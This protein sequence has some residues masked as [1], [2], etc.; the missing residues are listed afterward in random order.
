[1]SANAPAWHL[2]QYNIARLL[3][4]LD[5]PLLADFVA[6]LERVN[7]LGDASPGFVWRLQTDD[8]TSTSVRVRGD[9]RIIVNFTVWESI[10]AL[11]EFTY[12]SGHVEMYRRRREWFEHIAEAYLVLWWVPAGHIPSV[13]EAD[14]RL[15]YLRA[16]GPTEH[17]FTFKQRFDPPARMSTAPGHEEALRA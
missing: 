1:M 10:E 11:F 9:E 12:H 4:P 7:R 6:N 2:A 3:A 15:D 14:E 5:D 13:E 8:G 16:H 17:A